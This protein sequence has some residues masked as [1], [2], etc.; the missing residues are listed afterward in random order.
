MLAYSRNTGSSIEDAI[1][2]TGAETHA[3]GVAA[4][5]EFLKQKYKK[6]KIEFSIEDQQELRAG[7]RYY[8]ILRI[9]LSDG[10]R[11]T[12]FFDITESHDKFIIYP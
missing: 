9:K 8:D 5:Y 6:K 4:E 1:R 2:I 11:E 12:I 10:N 3:E 7:N